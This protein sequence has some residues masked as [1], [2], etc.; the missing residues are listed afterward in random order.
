[1]KQRIIRSADKK[2]G[3]ILVYDCVTASAMLATVDYLDESGT[4]KT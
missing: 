3:S 2:F 1:M 4:L